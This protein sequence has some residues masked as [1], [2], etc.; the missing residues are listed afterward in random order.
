MLR[1]TQTGTSSIGIK[2]CL[3]RSL[4][5]QWK[6]ASG[7]LNVLGRFDGADTDDSQMLE[8]PVPRYTRMCTLPTSLSLPSRGS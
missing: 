6:R 7:W 8:L 1:A 2:V 5:R 3:S 4:F